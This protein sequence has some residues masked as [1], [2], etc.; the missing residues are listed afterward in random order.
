M[1]SSV[2][3]LIG[4]EEREALCNGLEELCEEY[5]EGWESGSDEDDDEN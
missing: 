5:V 2:R 1:S 4:L 3:R